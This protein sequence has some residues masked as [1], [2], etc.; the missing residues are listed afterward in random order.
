MNIFIVTLGSRGEVQPYVALGKGLQAAGYTVT[1]CTSASFEPFI[2]GH[3][4]RY[5]YLS[6]D[7]IDLMD[8]AAGRDAMEDTVGV[9][10]AIRTTMKLAR[11]AN[12]INRQLMHETWTAAQIAAPAMVISHPKALAGTHV[13]EKLGVPAAIAL[14]VP[15][16]VATGEFP[17]TGMP[18]LA[19]GHAYN[20]LTY[21]AIALGYGMYDKMVNLFRQ[22]TLGLPAIRGAAIRLKMPDGSPIPVLH[23]VSNYVSPRPIDW[24]AHV[25]NT[26][27][28]FL[29]QGADWTPPTD[30]QRF[31]AAGAPPVYV[32][33]GSMAGRNPQRLTRIVIEALQRA[34]VR[35]LIATGWGGMNAGDLPGS[36]FALEQ[37]PHD[38]LLPR[39]AAVVH[40]GGAGT[41]AAGLR[42]GRPTVI[43]SFFAD[44]PY[45]GQRVHALGVGPKSIPQ[46]RLTAEGLTAAIVEVTRDQAMRGR[47]AEL[48]ARIS[49]EDGIGNAVAL[50]ERELGQKLRSTQR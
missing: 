13:A 18:L 2:T 35:G 34:N 36:I 25:Y 47:A 6:N 49:K 32:G 27:Y 40:H 26:G 21:Q 5:G 4:L 50:L 12:E 46:K 24:P 17:A 22:E 39:V 20:R 37:A 48:G 33:F 45:W 8:S 41:T 7:L 42:A 1:V 19:L 31:L 3:G 9:F 10:G 44:Q 16:I 29:D 14:P 11:R 15:L 23:G 30:L 28:W 38:W 43:C